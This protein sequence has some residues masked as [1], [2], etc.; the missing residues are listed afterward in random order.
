[1]RDWKPF[2]RERI[3]A[4]NL[5]PD[6][7]EEIVSEVAAHFEDIYEAARSEGLTEADALERATTV[8]V[9]WRRLAAQIQRTKQQ[10]ATMNDRTRQLWLPGLASFWAAM[11]CDLALGGGA[12]SG[13]S[14]FYSHTK[15]L[16]FALLLVAQLCCGA[17][18][19]FLSRR[20]GG[21]RS[22][23][24]AAA[25][26]PCGILLV[27]MFIVIAIC[28]VGRATGLAFAALDMTILIRPVLIVVLVPSIVMLLGALPFLSDT[29]R[30]AVA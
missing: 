12:L 1:M 8:E 29:K 15:Q 10:E 4:M 21:N 19:A 9:D 13:E 27:T 30:T 24:I 3:D 7:K 25:L 26:F 14:L 11:I 22:A 20:A 5:A 2:V 23:R 17:V 16:M 28:A 18:G 6:Q